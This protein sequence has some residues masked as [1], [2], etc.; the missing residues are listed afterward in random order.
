M[1]GD[2]VIVASNER[3]ADRPSASRL[4]GRLVVA[5]AAAAVVIGLASC[6][7]GTHSPH[8]ANLGTSR[9]GGGNSTTN[10]RGGTSAT[11]RPSSNPT[12]LLDEWA[13]CMRSHGDPNQADPTITADKVID[14]TWDP[15]IPGGIDGTNKGGQG[16]SGPGQYCRSYLDA[17]QSALRGGQTQEQP[18]QAQLLKFSECMRANGV[19]DFPDPSAGGGLSISLNAGGD[20]NPNS[21]VF[22]NASKL[23]AQ[24]TGVQGFAHA[25]Q[26]QPGMIELNG[27]APGGAGG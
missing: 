8:V 2:N 19:P 12:V 3:K 7:G 10:S 25:G 27:A 18:S 5:G 11:T 1:E 26:P 16:N 22:K 4:P 9:A 23:C 14:I 17:A 20:L 6:T 15:S 21:P 24:K 13:T